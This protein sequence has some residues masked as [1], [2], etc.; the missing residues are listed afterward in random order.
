MGNVVIV[1]YRPKPGREADLL[2]LAREHVP[3]LRR[4]GLASDRPA[5]LLQARDGVVVEVFEWKDGAMASAHQS[6]EVLALWARYAELCDYAPL[7]TLPE[8]AEMFATFAPVDG[9]AEPGGAACDRIEQ[10]K[11]PPDLVRKLDRTAEN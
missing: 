11:T 1:A 5:T 6:P 3:F 10:Q 2:A 4:L 8:C 7:R 9:P